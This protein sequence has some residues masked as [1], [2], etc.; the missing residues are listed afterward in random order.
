[1]CELCVRYR[2][3]F[4][5]VLIS[6]AV[7]RHKDKFVSVDEGKEGWYLPAGRVDAGETFATGAR[8]EAME[9]AG[10]D[11]ELTGLLRF[12]YSPSRTSSRFR[13]IYEAKPRDPKAPLKSVPDKESRGAA[14]VTVKE[15]SKLSLR[16]PEVQELFK[17]VHNGAKSAPLEILTGSNGSLIDS[18]RVF[19]RL[20]HVVKVLVIDRGRL[21]LR[22]SLRPEVLSS[23]SLSSHDTNSSV[24]TTTTANVE[25]TAT[26][27]V[28]SQVPVI[29]ATQE[30]CVPCARMRGDQPKDFAEFASAILSAVSGQSCPSVDVK[31]IVG[32]WHNAPDKPDEVGEM[33]VAFL[34]ELSSHDSVDAATWEKMGFSWLSMDQISPE[35]LNLQDNFFL[36]RARRQEII[37]PDFIA[38]EGVLR[39]AE[40]GKPQA[41]GKGKK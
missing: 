1:M 22:R 8:R 23:G 9:E 3:S 18:K 40:I 13:A 25:Q 20:Y 4:T 35:L 32:I 24:I 28:P 26:T 12:E 34:A 31:N 39:Q 7:V 19:T 11:I 5:S 17:W 41:A 36:D 6:M 33:G 2:D 30:F 14:W 37:S 29:E 38:L 27:A 15:L 16:S 10:C 21:L